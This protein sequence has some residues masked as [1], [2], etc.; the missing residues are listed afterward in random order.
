VTGKELVGVGA[1]ACWDTACIAVEDI[2]S[3]GPS[4]F[5]DLSSVC[6]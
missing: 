1:C 5:S 2:P 4:E 6:S 3:Q